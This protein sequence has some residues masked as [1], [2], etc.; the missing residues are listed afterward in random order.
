MIMSILCKHKMYNNIICDYRPIKTMKFKWDTS[1]I[2]THLEILF[3]IF[4]NFKH[5]NFGL[6]H[7]I[8]FNCFFSKISK[9]G[10]LTCAIDVFCVA[11]LLRICPPFCEA[12]GLN[13]SL[14]TVIFM[15]LSWN[16]FLINVRTAFHDSSLITHESGLGINGNTR[17]LI[18]FSL[19]CS[20][21]FNKL[22]CKFS[23]VGW[24]S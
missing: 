15:Q 2:F 20:I 8:L 16:K 9:N 1:L 19:V 12:T 3:C 6:E 14:Y 5:V 22:F 21:N 23:Y 18:S 4:C 10:V 17:L 13:L 11:V 24:S 7:A